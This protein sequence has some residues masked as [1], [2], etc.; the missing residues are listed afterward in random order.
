MV[1]IHIRSSGSLKVLKW[2]KCGGKFL[3]L[4]HLSFNQKVLVSSNLRPERTVQR[5]ASQSGSCFYSTTS[6]NLLKWT[7]NK[8]KTKTAHRKVWGQALPRQA[9]EVNIMICGSSVNHPSRTL[10]ALQTP[11]VR[12][13]NLP[14]T[15]QAVTWLSG[16]S[17]L[18]HNRAASC[19]F[20]GGSRKRSTDNK[21]QAL[22]SV[23]KRLTVV[24]SSVPGEKSSSQ[25][26]G[27]FFWKHSLVSVIE[28][29]FCHLSYPIWKAVSK[30]KR[31]EISEL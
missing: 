30:Q 27:V 23:V 12:V 21:R 18:C 22:R 13:V 7:M 1:K 16:S 10:A 5:L 26:S 19:L 28:I 2:S 17:H 29:H 6:S 25:P 4:L 14:L 8:A 20:S 15:S 11:K 3:W 24:F 9:S 31:G